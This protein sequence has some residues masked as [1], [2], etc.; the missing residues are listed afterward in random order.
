MLRLG[1]GRSRGFSTAAGGVDG[2]TR[3][4]RGYRGSDPAG[5]R[6]DDP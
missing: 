3:R 4:A 5:N 2:L 6:Q 1:A